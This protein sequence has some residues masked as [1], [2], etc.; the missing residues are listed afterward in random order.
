MLPYI[1]TLFTITVRGVTFKYAVALHKVKLFCPVWPANRYG[2]YSM[3]RSVTMP[4]PVFPK[5]HN[6]TR[7]PVLGP[8]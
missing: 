5:P 3:F 2:R 6:R 1:P 8:C 7:R 4:Y